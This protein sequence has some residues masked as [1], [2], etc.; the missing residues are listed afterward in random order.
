MITAVIVGA[1][2]PLVLFLAYR[3]WL[4]LGR[5]ELA[6]IWELILDTLL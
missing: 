2:W 3:L 4:H 1:L 6:E 5:P